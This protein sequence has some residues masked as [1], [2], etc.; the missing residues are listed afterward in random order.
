MPDPTAE[1]IVTRIDAA[2]RELVLDGPD[3]FAEADSL[4]DG[5][6]EHDLSWDRES[7]EESHFWEA[8]ELGQ[9]VRE[10]LRDGGT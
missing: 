3:S 7:G 2:Q 4:P 8:T 1:A 5:L 10:L 9:A 6:F